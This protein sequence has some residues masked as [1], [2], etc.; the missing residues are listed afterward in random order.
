MGLL[1]IAMEI[2][3]RWILEQDSETPPQD[4]L[5]TQAEET[6]TRSETMDTNI[7]LK[8]PEAALL[9]A[10]AVSLADD[11]PS[12]EEEVVL[13]KYFSRETA[14]EL[15]EKVSAAGINYPEELK[16]LEDKILEA[17]KAE[18]PL[19]QKRTLAVCLE[20]AMADGHVDQ[21]EMN[22]LNKYCGEFGLSLHDVDLFRQKKLKEL[23]EEGDYYSL[24]DISQEDIPLE[25][26][27][28]PQEAALAL[29][30]W[31]A[32]ADDDPSEPEIALIREYFS[33]E[34]ADSLMKKYQD[35]QA[36][37]PQDIPR[38]KDSILKTMH[39]LSRKDQLKYLTLLYK[40]AHADGVLDPR[41]DQIIEWFCTELMIGPNELEQC[42]PFVGSLFRN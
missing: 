26:D 34:E 23:S 10:A 32:F 7:D 9:L 15:E 30:T 21:Q 38:T 20:L 40:T 1:S 39:G 18:T 19:F 12:P 13:K 42:S 29:M 3:R 27:Y 25:M 14:R 6:T 17:L 11:N 36:A 31:T 24:E 28:S 37:F 35:A 8:G 2:R 41:E 5:E 22:W 33:A 16:A 4:S